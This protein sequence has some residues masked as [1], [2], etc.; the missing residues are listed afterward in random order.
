MIGYQVDIIKPDGTTMT[1]GPFNSYCGDSTAWFEMIPDQVGTWQFKFTFAGTY[2]PA[3]QYWDA[4]G[5]ETGGFI[6]SGKYFN[7]GA[8]IYYTP[9]ETDW[10]NLTVQENIVSSWPAT[11]SSVMGDYWTRPVN[12]M[13]RDLGTSIGDY[14]FNSILL[15]RR[16]R[17]LPRQ[18]NINSHAYVTAPNSAHVL[19]KR[20][21]DT[22]GPAGMVGGYTYEYSLAPSAG[23]P[24]IIYAGRCYQSISKSFDN[25]SMELFSNAMIYEPDKYTGNVQLLRSNTYHY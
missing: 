11:P 24:S 23:T 10:Q 2:I 14:P 12:P 22:T 6:A 9:E 7:L 13:W 25:G 15:S 21:L 18:H 1:V 8:S 16:T 17:T 4:P 19:W 20:T 3:G 5:S